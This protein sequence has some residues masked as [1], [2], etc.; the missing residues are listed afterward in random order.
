MRIDRKEYLNKI[1]DEIIA[2][3]R[4]SKFLI[5]DFTEGDSGTRGSVYFEAG[6]AQGLSI[7]VIFSCRKDSFDKIHFDTRQYPHIVWNSPE[8][9]KASLFRRISAVLGNGPNK[10]DTRES[11]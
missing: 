2:E 1:D 6:F 3:I 10:T 9:L 11:T 8:E 4:R 7:P 5:A